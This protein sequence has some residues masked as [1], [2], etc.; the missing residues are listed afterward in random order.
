MFSNCAEQSTIGRLRRPLFLGA[1]LVTLTAA[2][3]FPSAVGSLSNF[4]VVNDTPQP[5]HGFEIELE[6]LHVSDV[7]YTFGGT[8]IR[9]GA[10]EVLD[11]TVDAAH[12]RVLVRYRHWNGSHW[13]ATP[14]APVGITPGGHDCFANGPIGNYQASGCE[15]FGVS[16]NAAPTKTTYRWL[17]AADPSDANSAFT[18]V[19][20]T[21]NIP[22]PVWNV[23]VVGGGAVNVQAEVQPV[24]EENH[25][26]FGEPQWMKA[27][28]IQ[29]E[30]VLQPEDLDRLL[31]GAANGIVP[32]S[33]TEIETEWKLIQS[34]PGPGDGKD[35]DVKEDKLDKDKRS[36]IRRYEFYSYIG[37]R[38]PENNEALPCIAEGSPVPADAP[39]DGCADL[40]EFVGAQNVAID[41]LAAVQSPAGDCSGDGDVDIVELQEC[42]NAFMAGEILTCSLC[43]ND[44]NP[45]V[46]IVDLQA[47]VNCFLDPKGAQ[48]PRV[49]TP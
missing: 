48:C 30:I 40:G 7:P 16:L 20:Q 8:Y 45:G 2:P 44:G 33:E 31:L 24:E 32:D 9:Y 3:A 15:H 22:V 10:P 39:V 36:I 4:D 11:T 13:E 27:F 14:V 46:D 42:V 28:K 21:V 25:A 5:C 1:A 29:S 47:V 43:D 12:P 19:P 35:A 17:V 34:Q 37:P 6:D 38:D 41:A 26:Q 23:A 18:N 49:L